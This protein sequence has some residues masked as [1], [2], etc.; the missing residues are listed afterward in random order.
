MTMWYAYLCGKTANSDT[1][2]STILSALTC[3]KDCIF[4]YHVQSIH[5]NPQITSF[6]E[7]L[8]CE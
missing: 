5:Q 8:C 3:Q 4:S 6:L 1:D 2:Y 7:Y